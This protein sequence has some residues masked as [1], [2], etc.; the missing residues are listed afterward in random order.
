MTNLDGSR[1]HD[2]KWDILAGAM[3]REDTAR[4][5]YIYR[6]VLRAARAEGVDR[7]SPARFPRP[8]EWRRICLP[9]P[10]RAG[11]IGIRERPQRSNCP[12]C[13]RE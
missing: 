9:R 8:R 1:S 3:L 7:G 11:H 10:G 13:R 4:F 5:T 6:L 2:G 12:Q